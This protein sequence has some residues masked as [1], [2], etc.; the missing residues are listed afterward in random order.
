M[1]VLIVDLANAAREHS[2]ISH[3]SPCASQNAF[4]CMSGSISQAFHLHFSSAFNNNLICTIRF[5]Q[6]LSEVLQD[7]SDSLG[8]FKIGFVAM[9]PHKR[10]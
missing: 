10:K 1:R 2:P 3:T 6:Y 7:Q 9:L 8:E 5:V 4:V